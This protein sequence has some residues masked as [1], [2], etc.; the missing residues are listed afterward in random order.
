MIPFMSTSEP[1]TP[2]VSSQESTSSHLNFVPPNEIL[3]TTTGP[4]DGSEACPVSVSASSSQGDVSSS[5]QPKT[6]Q[7]FLPTTIQSVIQSGSLISPSTTLTQVWT[8]TLTPPPSAPPATVSYSGHEFR[9]S[10]PIATTSS[11][12]QSMQFPSP[13]PKLYAELFPLSSSQN[14]QGGAGTTGSIALS[15]LPLPLEELLAP[16][17]QKPNFMA[18]DSASGRGLK[19]SNRGNSR[20]NPYNKP[21]TSG[22]S[23]NSSPKK[24][25]LT[26]K[27]KQVQLL[28]TEEALFKENQWL[29]NSIQRNQ[30]AVERLQN[31]LTSLVREC[32]TIAPH[33]MPPTI[34]FLR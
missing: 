11:Q 1:K 25:G 13:T 27:Q 2:A 6:S 17:E 8:S 22:S 9:G 4:S 5:S 31:W 15:N 18:M 7:I 24:K 3:S 33:K 20:Y 10:E 32:R 14:N 26:K 30:E 29:K 23:N 19:N 28:K 16:E 12:I 34:S 21:G